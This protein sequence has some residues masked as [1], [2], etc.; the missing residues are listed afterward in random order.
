MPAPDPSM[1]TARCSGISRGPGAGGNG[2]NDGSG[3]GVQDC[4][5]RPRATP[6]DAIFQMPIN[7]KTK[8]IMKIAE[9][10]LGAKLAVAK[11]DNAAAISLLREAVAIQ[12]KLNYGEPPDWFYPVRESLGGVLLMSG[13]SAAAEKC[14]AK[15][16][17]GIPRNPRSL[18]GL[19]AVACCSRSATTMR[20]SCGNNLRASW[21][22]GAQSLKLDDL[23]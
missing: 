9:N 5:R 22:G 2:Q 21:K 10:V 4:L 23:V 17:N 18:W 20:D 7:N 19:H 15:I 16:S 6:P 1:K 3:S 12:D 8:D 13:D 14:S 11:K